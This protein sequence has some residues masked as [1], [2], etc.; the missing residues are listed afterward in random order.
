LII[1]AHSG[2]TA[3][4]PPSL[5]MIAVEPTV[6]HPV[7]WLSLRNKPAVSDVHIPVCALDPKRMLANRESRPS[8]CSA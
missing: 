3:V 8:A 1:E 4:A 5:P 6:P 2:C 7:N